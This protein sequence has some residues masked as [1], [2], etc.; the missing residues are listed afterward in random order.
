MKY[1]TIEIPFMHAMWILI[2]LAIYF[3]WLSGDKDILVLE[4]L[5]FKITD[6]K[7]RIFLGDLPTQI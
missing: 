6:N 7:D 5:K 1:S 3:V 4:L 2:Y